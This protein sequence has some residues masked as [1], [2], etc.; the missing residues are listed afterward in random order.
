MMQTV[1]GGGGPIVK[2]EVKLGKLLWGTHVLF[3]EG[4][5]TMNKEIK[6]ID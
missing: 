4:S 3:L 6:K 5:N 2:I 1:R